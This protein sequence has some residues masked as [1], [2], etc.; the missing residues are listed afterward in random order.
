MIDDYHNHTCIC[1]NCGGPM[2]KNSQYGMCDDCKTM[3]KERD[4]RKT[5]AYRKHQNPDRYY[6][7]VD[8][9]GNEDL[10]RLPV[11]KEE[12]Q[13][14]NYDWLTDATFEKCGQQYLFDGK[15]LK[16]RE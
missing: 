11:S 6:W 4:H 16:V 8:A 2:K 3:L 9:P 10:V 13:M 7:L 1:D 15:K 5:F 12:L 14:G